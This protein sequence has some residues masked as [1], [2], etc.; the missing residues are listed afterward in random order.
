MN[1]AGQLPTQCNCC[2]TSSAQQLRCGAALLLRPTV[3]PDPAGRMPLRPIRFHSCSHIV[4][5]PRQLP[6]LSSQ[7][8][9]VSCPP[10][11]LLQVSVDYSTLRDLLKEGKW[12]E[13]EDE[14]RELLIQ[15]AGETK[16][17]MLFVLA[18]HQDMCV[19]CLWRAGC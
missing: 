13:A 16:G 11:C 3:L 5:A 14:T 2:T 6:T 9:I 17:W 15:A 18:L 10:S 7:P 1:L 8:P 19:G 4:C 12:R